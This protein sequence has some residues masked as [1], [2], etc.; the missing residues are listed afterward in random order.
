MAAGALRTVPLAGELTSSLIYRAADRYG[1][2]AAG[3]LRQWTC[4]NSPARL[5]GGGVRA[6]AEI[7]LNDAGRGVLA[8]LCGVEPAVLAR[9]LPAFTVDDP[10]ISSGRE[11]GLAQARWRAAGAVAG[12]AAF[13]CR[14]CTARRTGQAQRA[15]RYLPRWQRVCDRHGR[16]LLDADADQPLE[17]LDLRSVPEV[18]EAQ[19]QWTGVA[20]RAGRAGVA[21]E[22]VFALA[23]AAVIRWW[24]EALHWE[25]EEIWLHRLHQVAG[26]NAGTDLQRWRIVGRDPVTFPEV[27]AVADALLDPAMTE[28]VWRDSGAGRPRPL[29]ADGAFCRRLGERVGRGWLGPLSAVDYGGP[30]LTWMGAVIRQRR[31]EGGPPGWRDDPWRLQR[32]QQPATMAGQ[33]RVMAAEQQSGGSGTRWRATVSAEHRFQIEQMIGEAQEQLVQ[34]RGVHSGTTAEVA[35]TLLEHLSHSAAL[36]D[37]ALVDTA[38]AAVAAGV[39][40]DEVAAWSRLPAQELAEIIT[41]GQDEE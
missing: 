20:R 34:L 3:L 8:E 40:L 21:P 28:L 4:R 5:D 23:H 41:A 37:Q 14:P 1:L 12:E 24:D 9:A 18:A 13:A 36:I 27:V 29:P 35:R 30:L 26:G 17:H 32:E 19:R 7:V 39:A 33:L 25:Q 15:V 2:P 11:A 31:A 16:W 6:D 10:K 22:Q 38:A